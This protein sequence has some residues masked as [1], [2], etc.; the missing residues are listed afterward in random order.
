MNKQAQ[1]ISGEEPFYVSKSY[2][3]IDTCA[4]DYTLQVSVDYDEEHPSAAS[5]ADYS[6]EIPASSGPHEVGP[7]AKNLWWRL[8]DNTSEILI[9]Y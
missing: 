6:D 9:R 2:F 7:V 1:K 5:W 3:M 4:D 8:K